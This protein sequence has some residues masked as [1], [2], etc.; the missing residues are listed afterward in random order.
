MTHRAPWVAKAICCNYSQDTYRFATWEE[1]NQFRED[2]TRPNQTVAEHGFS[3][4]VSESGHRRAVII[5][6]SEEEA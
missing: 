3:A 2:F 4:R 1:A 5:S 6:F